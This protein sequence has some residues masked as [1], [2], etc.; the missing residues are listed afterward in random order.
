M[1]QAKQTYRV[2]SDRCEL[3]RGSK[4]NVRPGP[5]ENGGLALFKIN[6]LHIIGRFYGV[7]A[8][9]DFVIQPHRWIRI[10]NPADVQLLGAVIA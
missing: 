7:A 6:G 1:I 10:H 5:V 3:K 9:F 8:G 2:V 4:F